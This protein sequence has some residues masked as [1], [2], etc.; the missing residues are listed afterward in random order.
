MSL[1]K[2]IPDMK[3]KCT[4]RISHFSDELIK[5]RSGRV[6][7]SL[8]EHIK[9]EAYGA[10]MPLNQVATISVPD[11]KCLAVQPW[12]KTLIEEVEK[13]LLKADVGVTPS[14]DGNLIRLH[15]PPLS[16]ERRK[17]WVKN[18]KQL[19]EETKVACRQI[20]KDAMSELQKFKKE[21]AEDDLKRI[22]DSIQKELTAQEKKISDLTE[23]KA[24]ELMKF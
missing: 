20:R 1:D 21:M 3:A 12:D 2:I 18:V 13:A 19:S 14:N 10:L 24:A 7:P 15:F 16:E 9:V 4:L 6:N 23:Q 17:E 22:E 8:I 5:I 11:P